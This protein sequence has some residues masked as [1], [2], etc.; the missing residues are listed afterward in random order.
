M[1]EVFHSNL[2]GMSTRTNGREATPFNVRV[3]QR[4]PKRDVVFQTPIQTMT[5][6]K[7][8]PK[9]GLQRR[10]AVR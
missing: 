4:I 6:L 2:N 7:T 10:P 3:D 1:I 5:R 9:A 8:V